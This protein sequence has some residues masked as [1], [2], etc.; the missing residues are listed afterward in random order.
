MDISSLRPGDAVEL[1]VDANVIPAGCYR[2]REVYGEMSVFTVGR[3]VVIG[4][5]TEFWA[6]FMRPASESGAK[7]SSVDEFTQAYSRLWAEQQNRSIPADPS[8]LT[9]CFISP[10]ALKKSSRWIRRP[11]HPMPA[12][13]LLN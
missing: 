13:Q 2:F 6:K 4:L 1:L 8:R 11:V 9:F 12:W 3:D 5:T 7:I 10:R